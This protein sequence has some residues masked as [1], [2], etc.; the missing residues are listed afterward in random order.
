MPK[1]TP[2]FTQPSTT[3]AWQVTPLERHLARQTY[4]DAATQTLLVDARGWLKDQPG[5][6]DGVITVP[7]WDAMMLSKASIPR[8]PE[9]LKVLAWPDHGALKDWR[10]PIPAWV[11]QSCAMFPSHQLR[12]LHFVGRYPQLLELLDHSPVLAWQLVGSDLSES[13]VVALLQGKQT[14]LMAELGWPGK[15][16]ALAFLRKL[17]LRFVNDELADSVETCLL[18]DSRLQALQALPRVNSM[19]LALAARFPQWIGTRLHL[20]LAQQPCRPMQCQSLLALLQDMTDL[21][22]ALELPDSEREKVTQCRYLVEVEQLYR[23][24]ADLPLLVDTEFDQTVSQLQLTERPRLLETQSEWE[25]LGRLQQHA[26]WVDWDQA[27][28]QGDQLYAFVQQGVVQA[29]RIDPE[30]RLSA[31]AKALKKLRQNDNALPEAQAWSKWHLWLAGQS[32]KED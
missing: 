13:D 25:A 17:R 20:S 2:T 16:E 9:H 10:K 22:A 8:Y 28:E 7:G 31:P 3:T 12:L 19:A 26:W 18:D 29:A 24:W 23:L 30:K 6:V 15:R 21:M 4:W 11:W 5:V 14:D 1:M 32:P 27:S